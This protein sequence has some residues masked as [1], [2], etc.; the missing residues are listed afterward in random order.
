M[1]N[2]QQP[3]N[4]EETQFYIQAT[5]A[6]STERALVLKQDET[7]GVFDHHGDVTGSMSVAGVT[8]RHGPAQLA[9]FG[10]LVTGYAARLSESIGWSREVASAK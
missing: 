4:L 6:P 3:V 10:E 1:T 9:E 8:V 2:P 5:T 7:F